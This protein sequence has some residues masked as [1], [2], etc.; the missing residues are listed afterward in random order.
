MRF[1]M[2]AASLSCAVPLPLAFAYAVAW[3]LRRVAA[4]S[5]AS[6]RRSARLG[7]ERHAWHASAQVH[8]AT[9]NTMITACD[10]ACGR[11]L[12]AEPCNGLRCCKAHQSVIVLVM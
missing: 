10:V 4:A 11:L 6:S 8:Y 2:C 12:S 1:L 5:A 7:E 9:F 3:D